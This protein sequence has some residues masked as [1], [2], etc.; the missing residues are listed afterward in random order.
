MEMGSI[1]WYIGWYCFIHVPLVGKNRPLSNWGY[2]LVT[3]DD[4]D[5]SYEIEL[6]NALIEIPS[7][8]SVVKHV[9][10]TCTPVALLSVYLVFYDEINTLIAM[11]S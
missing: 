2:P 3:D 7:T 4:Y 1:L 10:L 8:R 11:Y 9:I 5:N 6:A